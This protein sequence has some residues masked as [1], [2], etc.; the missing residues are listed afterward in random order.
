MERE[1]RIEAARVTDARAIARGIMMAVGE[2]ICR[3]FA[4][5]GK[6]MEDV[7][8]VFTELAGREG[9]QYSYRNAVVARVVSGAEA[10]SEGS[11]EGGCNGILDGDVVGVAV[12]YDGSMLKPWR[13]AFFEVAER[14]VGYRRERM[15]GDETNADEFYLDTLAVAPGWR[16]CGL[17]RK[18]IM[19]QAGRATKPMGLLVEKENRSAQRLYRACGFRG[20]GERPFA[21]VSMYHWVRE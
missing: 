12:A 15:T 17:G 16:G 8:R 3:D 4:G 9:T 2:E 6:T 19:E 1:I 7:E 5:E 13:E 10:A 18:L 20:V 21:G 14:V 11:D